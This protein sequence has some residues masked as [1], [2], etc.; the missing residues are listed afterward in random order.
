MKKLVGLTSLISGMLLI[1]VPR[2]ILPAC[3][4]AGFS[5]MHCSDTAQ[6][7]YIVGGLLMAVG[8]TALLVRHANAA[9]IASAASFLLFCIAIWLPEKTGYCQSTRMPCNYG[10]VPG[11]RFIAAIGLLI[12]ASAM[13]GIVRAHRRKGIS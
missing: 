11:I 10:M 6:A 12:M 7:E 1:L 13:I 5:R 8:I 9:V 2:Y 4:Y 3:E